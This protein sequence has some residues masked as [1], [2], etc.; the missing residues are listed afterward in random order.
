MNVKGVYLHC[1]NEESA[2]ILSALG[3]HAV[4]IT[5]TVSVYMYVTLF[6]GQSSSGSS[7]L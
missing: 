6:K 5:N 4:V 7:W 3:P 2:T 1:H